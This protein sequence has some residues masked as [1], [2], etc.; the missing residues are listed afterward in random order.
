[1]SVVASDDIRSCCYRCHGCGETATG[2]EEIKA[3]CADASIL[4]FLT[5][6]KYGMHTTTTNTTE[7]LP[8][9][10]VFMGAVFLIGLTL[11]FSVYRHT[12]VL[13]VVLLH[14]LL[15]PFGSHG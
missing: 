8:V 11:T 4:E 5:T 7:E 9:W 13:A 2:T 3:D 15:M 10:L 14:C 1:M 6:W 12:K